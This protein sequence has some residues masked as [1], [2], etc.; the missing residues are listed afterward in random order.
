MDYTKFLKAD[1]PAA[2]A[3]P[4]PAPTRAGRKPAKGRLVEQYEYINGDRQRRTSRLVNGSTQTRRSHGIKRI[5]FPP[6]GIERRVRKI[7]EN[8]FFH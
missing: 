8:S 7:V 1:Q 5:M 4:I 3:V 2:A 6:N